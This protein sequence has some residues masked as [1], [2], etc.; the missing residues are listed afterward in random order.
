MSGTDWITPGLVVAVGIA[1]WRLIHSD[2]QEFKGEV[3]ENLARLNERL[4]R[5]LEGH[6]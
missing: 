4:D 3:R 2:I 1:L 6:P 5:H